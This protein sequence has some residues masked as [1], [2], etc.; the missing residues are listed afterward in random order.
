MIDVRVDEPSH[1]LVER[2]YA[3]TEGNPF[4]LAEVVNLMTEEGSISSDSVSDIA[5]PEGVR[6][7]LGRRLDRLSEEANSLLQY[8][9]V[10]GRHVAGGDEVEVLLYDEHPEA[11]L[12]QATGEDA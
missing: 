7:A 8:A 11:G 12:L 3:E 4:F 2:V 5:I 6:E 9:A 1:A 10:A